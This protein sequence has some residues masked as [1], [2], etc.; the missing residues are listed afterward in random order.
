MD[1][2]AAEVAATLAKAEG[3]FDNVVKDRKIAEADAKNKRGKVNDLRKQLAAAEKALAD[4][5]ILLADIRAEEDRL[6]K[7]IAGIAK[8]LK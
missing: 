1:N 8:N 3:E 6:P 4:A 7:V 2:Q 5:E